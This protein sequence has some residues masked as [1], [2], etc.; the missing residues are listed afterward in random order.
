MSMK[1]PQAPNA[2]LFKQGYS[3]YSNADGQINKSIAAIREIHQMCLTSMGPCGRNKIIVNH[4]GKAVVTNDAATMLRELDIVHPAVKVLVMATEQQKIDMGDGTNLVM[5]LAGELLNV[6]EKLIALGLSAVEIIQG[7]NMAMNYTLKALDELVVDEITLKNDPDQ[8]AKITRSV[9]AAKQYGHEELLSKLVAEAVSHVLPSKQDTG[10]T[11]FNVDSIRVVKIMGGSLSNSSV[12]KGMVFNREPEGHVKTLTSGKKHKVAVFT[13]PLDIAATETKGTVLLHNAQEMLDFSKG[14]EQQIDSMM[15]AIADMGVECVVAGAGVGELALHYLNRYGILVL[16]VPSKFELRR[17]C[18]V[19]GATPLARLGAP[20][21]E[22]A[23]TVD[24]VKTMEIGGDRVT[25]FKQEDDE[26]SRTATIILRGATQNHLDDIE[27]A[28]DDGVSAIKGLMKT[29][30]GKLL[31]GAGATE[32]ELVSRIT[33]FGEK[34]PGLLQL[35]IKQF[36]LAFEIVPR[37]LAETSG[38][39][40]NEVLPNLYAAHNDDSGSG[41]YKGIDIDSESAD[42]LK[43]IRE[44]NIYDMLEMKKFAVNVATEA[45]CTVLSVDQIIMAKKAGGPAAPPRGPKPGNWDHDD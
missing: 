19:C 35:A 45:A 11:S 13:C 3:S 9:I 14:E 26:V 36:A 32:I 10:F 21:P 30:G 37:T 5:I 42:G 12:I 43:D 34:T 7:Y 24:V 18:R 27:R 31:P 15:K 28:I 25:V 44:E 22:E 40:V 6:S 4:L 17:I 38:Q 23:G 20:T 2:G 39:D 41:I 8:L 33:K 1:L 29:D 16:K